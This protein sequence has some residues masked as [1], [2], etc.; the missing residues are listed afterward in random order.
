MN[1]LVLGESQSIHQQRMSRAM[2]ERGH[3]V[4]FAGLGARPST[5]LEVIDLE[6]G[7]GG[8]PGIRFAR[9]IRRLRRIIR[10]RRVDLLHAHYVTVYGALAALAGSVPKVL[11]AHGSDVLLAREKRYNRLVIRAVTA[12]MDRITAASPQ[13]AA[14]LVAL[15][16]PAGRIETFQYGVDLRRFH[17]P[18]AP[19]SLAGPLRVVSTRRLEPLYRV[20]LLLMALS[21]MTCR[22]RMETL[23]A[24]GGSE[25][26]RLGRLAW[27]L[28]L[29]DEVRFLGPLDEEG[30]AGAL[31]SADVYV[32]TAPTDG[33]SLSLLEAMATGLLPV[34]PDIPANREW[35]R[36]GENGL[37]F[38]PGVPDALAGAL[39]EAS[40]ATG[41]REKARALNPAIVRER[42]GF[43][44]GIQRLEAL[45]EKLLQD[46]GRRR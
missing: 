6:E 27:S 45:Y 39:L 20:D 14:A 11:T 41:L 32:T 17:P 9:K 40:H 23:V 46:R 36:P 37:L 42:A 10:R 34:A 38:A 18:D 30:V 5:G 12:R 7:G 3:T 29:E 35:I 15:G 26:E 16:A 22:G 24:G 13:V 25:E 8:A 33:A 1:L 28:Q 2:A 43:D 44:A 31:R 19:R 21:R 4:L